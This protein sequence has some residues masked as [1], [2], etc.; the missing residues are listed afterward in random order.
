MLYYDH[1]VTAQESGMMLE[2][3]LRPLHFSR[4]LRRLLKEEQAV[5]VN[6]QA[7]Y[8]RNRVLKGDHITVRSPLDDRLVV[9][10]EDIPIAVA[11]EDDHVL[12]VDKPPGMLIHPVGRQRSHTLMAAVVHY[13]QQKGENS[14]VFLLH[15]LDQDTSGL[16]LLAKHKLAQERLSRALLQRTIHRRYT[17]FVHGVIQDA[18]RV[19][20]APIVPVPASAT[21]HAVAPYGRHAVTQVM[22]IKRYQVQDATQLSLDLLTGRTH[23]IR[24][25]LSFICHPLIGDPLYGIQSMK[26]S[27]YG[28]VRQAL[29]ASLLTFAHPI[30]HNT[31]VVESAL[32]SD[33]RCVERKLAQNESDPNF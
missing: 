20:E 1:I 18:F 8:W 11:F 25:H 30:S 21:K 16:V 28:L 33:L 26:D 27:D 24:V 29:H 9:E 22:T 5:L 7:F 31:V 14:R 2:T 17:A 23:Q 13:L 19:I 3:L 12:V 15:R 4:K 10:P 6:G 32:P